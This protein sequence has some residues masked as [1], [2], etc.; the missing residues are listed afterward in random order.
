M[1]HHLRD[2]IRHLLALVLV[3]GTLAGTVWTFS[4]GGITLGGAGERLIS[5]GGIALAL[6]LGVIYLAWHMGQLD[7]RIKAARR[8]DVIAALRGQLRGLYVYFAVVAAISA[9]ANFLFRVQQLRNGWLAAFVALAPI[10][11]VWVF[12]VVLRPLPEDYRDMAARATGRALVEMIRQADATMRQQMRRMARG[13]PLT[14]EDLRQLSFSTAVIRMHAQTDEQQALDHAVSIALPAPEP[15]VEAVV[16]PWLTTED[17]MQRYGISRRTAQA[18]MQHVPGARRIPNS[19]AWEAP[20][21]QIVAR[22]PRVTP[23]SVRGEAPID[24]G[25]AQRGAVE[26]L[27]SAAYALASAADTNPLRDTGAGDTLDTLDFA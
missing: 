24:A 13:R 17:L 11:L 25:E 15:A 26:P 9:V 16:D 5:V 6:E 14:E 8:R 3:S 7:Q 10:A 19:N 18:R 22:W 23:R 1:L 27:S 20:E 12:L 21:S 4:N 2:S